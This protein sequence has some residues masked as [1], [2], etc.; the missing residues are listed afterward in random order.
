VIAPPRLVAEQAFS[1]PAG[2][3]LVQENRIRILKIGQGN[4]PAWLDALGAARKTVHFES[5]IIHADDIGYRFA[6]LLCTNARKVLPAERRD[7]KVS[8]AGSSRG[9]AGRTATGTVFFEI[10]A[11]WCVRIAASAM[12]HTERGAASNLKGPSEGPSE[13]VSPINSPPQRGYEGLSRICKPVFLGTLG[14]FG[15]CRKPQRS[16][17]RTD[18]FLRQACLRGKCDSSTVFSISI[19]WLCGRQP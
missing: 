13:R 3:P 19:S 11:N 15:R 9:N 1:R 14:R 18:I 17:N 5:Y 7:R 16:D 12:G 2:A 10:P 8:G 4:Y 6:D